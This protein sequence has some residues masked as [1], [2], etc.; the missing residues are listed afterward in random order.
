MVNEGRPEDLET[1]PLTDRIF[2][3]FSESL[4]ATKEFD[5]DTVRQLVALAKGE[6]PPK[7]ADIEKLL[8][9]EERLE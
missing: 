6:T 2:A 1:G 7:P 5:E 3:R 8:K 9:Q 4:L